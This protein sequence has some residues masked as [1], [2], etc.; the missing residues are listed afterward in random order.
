MFDQ[1]YE[2]GPFRLL[3]SRHALL[4]DGRAVRLGSRALEILLL[5]VENAGDLVGKEALLQRVWPD[6]IVEEGALRTH[7]GALRKALG[8]GQEE[9]RYILNVTGRGYRFVAPVTMV[10][11]T[12]AAE[13]ETETAYSAPLAQHNLPARL[14]R[15]I[16]RDE[17]VPAVRQQ[18]TQ[19]RFVTIVGPGG[20]GKTTVALAVAEGLVESFAGGVRFVDLSAVSDPMHVPNALGSALEI[21]VV[22]EN[23]LPGLIDFLRRRQMLL[24]LD[25]CEHVIDA[26]ARLAEAILRRAPDI[27]LLATSREPIRAEGERIYRLAPMAVPPAGTGLAVAEALRYPAIELFAERALSGLGGS[28]LT[29]GDA[30]LIAET[31]RRLDGI[32]LAIELVAARVDQ[33]GLR[34]LAAMLD[35]HFLVSTQ[36]RRTSIARHRT[37]GDL[38]GWSFALL[39]PIEQTV[40]LRLSVFRGRFT[41]KGAVAVASDDGA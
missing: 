4:R 30:A 21:S 34:G 3:A 1:T 16:G 37:L 15:M 2:F 33:L 20:I 27:A 19:R 22:V 28:E 25:N 32:P 14:N 31:C 10:P 26:V 41:L 24:V 13:A 11:L 39:S 12:A 8:D 17:V 7:I 18:V 5:L 6:T 23:P 36:G 35:D 29:D 40:L 38:M 9:A